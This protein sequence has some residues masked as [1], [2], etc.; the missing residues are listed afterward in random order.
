MSSSSRKMLQAAAGN[1]GGGDFYP[2]TVDNSCRF[3][4]NDSA[5]LTRTPGSAG[6]S[7][8]LW[9]MSFWCK[10]GNIGTS[11]QIASAGTS[12]TNDTFIYF[13]ADDTFGIGNRT[14]STLDTWKTSTAVF[15]DPSAWYHFVVRWDTAN[16]TAADRVKI[17]VN[18]EEITAWTNDNN[19]SA[20]EA[21]HWNNNVVHDI[22]RSVS[23]SQYCDLYLSQFAFCDGQS[24]SPSDFGEDKNGIWVPKNVSGL[25]FG[26]NGFLLDFG[27]SAALGTDVSGN[28]NNFTSS[29][30]TSSDQMIDTPTNNFATINP[31]AYRQGVTRDTVYSEGNTQTTT[32]NSQEHYGW[33]LSRS[34]TWY[35]EVSSPNLGTTGYRMK[36]GVS[37][38][39]MGPS[40]NTKTVQLYSDGFAATRSGDVLKYNSEVKSGNGS[41]TGNVSAN[42]IVGLCY[43]AD[44]LTLDFFINGISY[45]QVT[46]LD[47]VPHHI[48]GA[49]DGTPSTAQDTILNWNFG[50][51]GDFNGQHTAQ[52]NA[53]ENGYGDFYYTPPSGA[54]AICTANFPEPT[55]GPNSDIKPED[56]FAIVLYTGNGTAIGSG[57]KVI[58]G[59]G[60]QPDMVW[61]K[62]RD[63]ADSWMV[64][65]SVRGA[66]KYIS[67]DSTNVEATDTESLSTFDADGFT[68]GNNV[69]VN[70]NTEEY[71]AYCFKITAGFLDI[72]TWPGNNEVP[73]N[74]AH[75]LGVVPDLIIGH[76]LT[77]AGAAD[78]PVYC[79]SL[80]VADPETDYLRL[81]LT[82]AVAD[83]TT[84]WDDTAPTSTQFRVGTWTALNQNTDDHIGY[85]FA[86]V[87]GFCKIGYYEGNGSADGPFQYAGF[88]PDFHIIKRTNAVESWT[89]FDSARN[90]SNPCDHRIWTNLNNAE[91]DFDQVD[92]V[93]NGAKLRNGADSVNGNTSDYITLSIGI[94]D[95]YANAR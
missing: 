20:S 48:Y 31:L 47:D 4:D 61:I 19:S 28:G 59:V 88:S 75:S 7:R 73:Q 93:S 27:N 39:S 50:Q 52:G 74:I 67:L 36:L 58:T 71:V 66:T 10:R 5:Y 90:P 80:P 86:N 12:G 83:S 1:A 91:S 60:F 54:L 8:V 43:D 32:G 56:C 79:S 13:L 46:G 76:R 37:K 57:G 22:G 29:G 87:P 63:A 15:R 30:L 2:Y 9:T 14:S 77:G 18:N 41:T 35:W 68:L 6:D 49:S 85:L 82:N 64:F 33:G 16:G 23:S 89:V 21:S 81:N 40:D 44:N 51:N 45:Y 78:W 38:V 69:A 3:N 11:Q 84:P 25:T 70:T 65:D 92:F 53:D 72:V 17:W 34:G 26:T 95:K 62:N 24:Y 94:T 55:I 42:D